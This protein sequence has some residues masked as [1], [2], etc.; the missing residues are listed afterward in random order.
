[1]DKSWI[2]MHRSSDEYIKGV[3]SF[4]DFAFAHTLD[5]KVI[6]CP[7]TK[8]QVG[9]NAWFSGDIVTRHLMFNGFMRSYK[10]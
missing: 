5:P 1:M 4:L 7:Y 8:C 9:K 2:N 10:D 6:T 3:E